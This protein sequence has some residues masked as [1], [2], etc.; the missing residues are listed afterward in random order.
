MNENLYEMFDKVLLDA[1][2]SGLGVVRR[3]PDIL[4]KITPERIDSIINDQKLL[5]ESANKHLKVGGVLVY[6]TCTINKNENE[7]QIAKFIEN[8]PNYQLIEE[9]VI[10]PY[11]YNS[12]GFYIAKLKK[13][14][15]HA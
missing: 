3:K 7:K 4:R 13:G 10:L 11:E 15:P 14:E 2:C 9:K 6:S 1:P 8:H 5:L 12:D